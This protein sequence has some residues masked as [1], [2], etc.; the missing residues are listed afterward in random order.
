MT[1]Y[2]HEEFDRRIT[3]DMDPALVPLYLWMSKREHPR[4]RLYGESGYS[5]YLTR[6]FTGGER[7]D[8][9]KIHFHAPSNGIR[10]TLVPFD[11]RHLELKV[12]GRWR[13]ALEVLDE[14][15]RRLHHL[16]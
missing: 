7:I 11:M 9:A 16:H 15:W 8:S 4:A 5:G 13:P 12:D 3:K 6:T 1:D 2:K 10:Y 14:W